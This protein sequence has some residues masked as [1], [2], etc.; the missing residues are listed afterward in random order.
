MKINKK[1]GIIFLLIMVLSLA[2]GGCANNDNNKEK[3]RGEIKVYTTFY[4]LYDFTS[5]I[6][7]DRIQVVNMVPAGVEP[8]DFEPS[9]RQIAD[10]NHGQGLIFLGEP[11]D[12]WA[13]KV[14]KDI[15]PKGV[16]VLEAGRGLI[17]NNDPH[18]WLDPTLAKDLSSRILDFLLKLDGDNEDYYQENFDLLEESFDKLDELY[19]EELKEVT[20]KDLVVSHAALGYL[21]DRYGLNQIPITG[22]SP[23]EEPSP[24][25]MAELSKILREKDISY[26]FFEELASPK[27]SETLAKEVGAELLVFNPLDGISKE[28]MDNGQDYF[29][30][31][32][33]NLVNIRKALE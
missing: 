5:K 28:E 13:V 25:K 21:V 17:E 33:R 22:L 3:K 31:M 19:R 30:I 4:P 6:G 20:R 1:G 7:G 16:E 14:G 12:T 32:E 26:I 29:S 15:G 11:M 24:K 2:L 9:P 8:H 23:Q 18:I 10:L 27:L